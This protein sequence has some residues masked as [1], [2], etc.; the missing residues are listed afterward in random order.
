MGCAVFTFLTIYSLQANKSNA[1]LVGA[2]AVA[3]VLL[4]LVASYKTWK[5]E[6][7]EYEL[8]A[9]RNKLPDIR[10]SFSKL[11]FGN[12]FDGFMF[13]LLVCNHA[14]AETNIR[15]VFVQLSDGATGE[16]QT[17]KAVL[18]PDG[19]ATR[20]QYGIAQ[21]FVG[22]LTCAHPLFVSAIR[23][24]LIDGLGREYM[25]P[26]EGSYP[27][28]IEIERELSIDPILYVAKW[29][30]SRFRFHRVTTEL[31]GYLASGKKILA[32][33][34]FFVDHWPGKDKYLLVKDSLDGGKTQKWFT[35]KQGDPVVFP[36]GSAVV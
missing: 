28:S 29:G 32:A 31:R 34:E 35:F 8:Q 1:W 17:V 7:I 13:T 4:L 22:T 16:S 15:D 33:N 26:C 9:T 30:I 2:S 5:E 14:Q 10:G 25:I 18:I 21:S 23:I 24:R 20:L 19:R 6:H 3:A 11:E 36:P 27:P 12:G